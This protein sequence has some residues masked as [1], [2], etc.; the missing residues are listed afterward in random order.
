M[1]VIL[2]GAV[3]ATLVAWNAFDLFQTVKDIPLVEKQ[4]DELKPFVVENLDKAKPFVDVLPGR[5]T[6]LRQKWG[7]YSFRSIPPSSALRKQMPDLYKQQK[8]IDGLCGIP[9]P[10]LYIG[11]PWKRRLNPLIEVDHI[12]P[13]SKGGSDAV[14]NLQLTHRD[15][16]RAKSNLENSTFLKA[17][18][19]NKK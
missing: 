8:G 10:N 3:T 2:I 4:V 17:D 1:K 11:L 15:F 9:L 6:K 7:T 5:F 13:K 19:C 14:S 16:N 12:I 18:I